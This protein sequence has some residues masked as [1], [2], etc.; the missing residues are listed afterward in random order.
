MGVT[1]GNQM[2]VSCAI[3]SYHGG[4]DRKAQQL[5]KIRTKVRYQQSAGMVSPLMDCAMAFEQET[6]KGGSETHRHV[7]TYGCLPCT[8]TSTKQGRI[9]EAE[10]WPPE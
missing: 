1:A 6:P 10:V 2:E 7:N 4:H 8:T 5:V 3:Q 9:T